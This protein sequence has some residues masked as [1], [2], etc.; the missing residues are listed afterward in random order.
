MKN[1]LVGLLVGLL[2]GATLLYFCWA[3]PAL[4][5]ANESVV[6]R[7]D[8]L[9]VRDTLT[10]TEVREVTRRVTDTIRVEVPTTQYDTIVVSLPRESVTYADSSYYAVVSGFQPV[11]DTI[12]V[13]PVS[14]TIYIETQRPTRV[15]RWGLSVVGGGGFGAQGLTPFVGVGVSWDILQW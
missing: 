4:E 15:K 10:I 7:T 1:A 13:F 6:V 9:V 11:L 2:V 3:R 8:T 14:T 5:H 12:K